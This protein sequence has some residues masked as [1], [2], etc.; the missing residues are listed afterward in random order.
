VIGMMP[1][2]ERAA[3]PLLGNADGIQLF[4]NLI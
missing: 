4:K 1:H 3:A 2:P